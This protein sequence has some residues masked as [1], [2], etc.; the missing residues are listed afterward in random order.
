MM[1]LLAWA[2]YSSSA[3]TLQAPPNPLQAS[4]V[5]ILSFEPFIAHISNFVSEAERRYLLELGLGWR[6]IRKCLQR[7][8]ILQMI[9]FFRNESSHTT[10]ALQIPKVLS[11]HFPTLTVY[12]KDPFSP[13]RY[14]LPVRSQSK[15]IPSILVTSST[16]G[17]K[18]SARHAQVV[19]S[20]SETAQLSRAGNKYRTRR[21]KVSNRLDGVS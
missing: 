6:G 14:L 16:T 7:P 15:H 12:A 10:L 17:E 8:L 2:R 20:F 18:C 5:K 11:L 1:Q 13:P 3:A 19:A 21:T 4:N 9:I